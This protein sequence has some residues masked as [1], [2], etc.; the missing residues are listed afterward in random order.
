MASAMQDLVI[1]LGANTAGFSR[2]MKGARMQMR[3]VA[4]GAMSM[5]RAFAPLGGMAMF[6]GMMRSAE[7]FN[8]KMNQSL[9]IMGNV[10]AEMR[11]DMKQAAF[12]VAKSTKYAA[13]EAAEAYFFLASAGLDAKQSIA[14]LPAVAAFAQAGNF[15]LATAT[16]LAT[17]AQSAMGLTVKDASRNLQNL[18]RVTDVLTMANT[19]ANA[20][21]RQFSEALTNKAGAALRAAGK[22]IE[23]GTAVLAAWADQGLKGADAG[24]AMN[25]VLRD[26]QTKSRTNTEAWEAAGI[27]VYDAS[28]A[29]NNMADIVGD[30]ETHLGDMSVEQQNAAIATL[31]FTDKSKIF[32]QT[33]LGMSE[34]I[35]EYEK[36][37]KSA[38]GTTAKVAGE[39]LTPFQKAMALLTG[40]VTEL[41]VKLMEHLG[42]ALV[43]TI[44]IIVVLTRSIVGSMTA[45]AGLF[46]GLSKVVPWIF[47]LIAA[48]AG[49][50]LAIMAVNAAI[51]L[52]TTAT[53]AA[54]GA[55]M[56]LH[57]LG[58]PAAWAK[59]AIGIA[60]ATAAV[61][62]M[63]AVI[64]DATQE[65]AAQAEATGKAAAALEEMTKQQDEL[66]KVLESMKDLEETTGGVADNLADVNAAM[67]TATGGVAGASPAVPTA[68]DDS[69]VREQRKADLRLRAFSAEES[70]AR[71][72]SLI[73]S[74]G[75]DPAGV[76]VTEWGQLEQ[77]LSRLSVD[78]AR[79]VSRLRDLMAQAGIAESPT[80]QLGAVDDFV[81]RS[82]AD[83]RISSQTVGRPGAVGVDTQQAFSDI[84][85]ATDAAKANPETVR[86][87]QLDKQNELQAKAVDLLK[88]IADNEIV[89]KE[90]D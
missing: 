12:D 53:K 8:Q 3:G 31:G 87:G 64:D 5:I 45:F 36:A 52:Y 43:D 79:D 86:K 44:R 42:P 32:I 17:D 22:D 76:G 75:M 61:Y 74:R 2:G 55:S 39:Q 6:A 25:I 27:A 40:T 62:A 70:G 73:R 60:G 33:L 72:S 14:A 57:A 54:A 71:A 29:M 20:S 16:D 15:D 58:G 37:L 48:F 89:L 65:S 21:S 41:G 80:P 88:E 23:E 10:S 66:N 26:L 49:A 67:P 82:T 19:L 13:S 11:G 51:W 38:G 59:T 63:S 34:K 81:A 78:P 69:A 1:R 35:R 46:G 28:G 85:K 77:E 90:I 7:G 9:A 30:L 56:F 68:V 24:T 18:T 47:R 4:S 50:K 84:F 83:E